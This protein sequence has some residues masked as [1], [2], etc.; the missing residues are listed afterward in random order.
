[1]VDRLALLLQLRKCVGSDRLSLVRQRLAG[2]ESLCATVQPIRTCGIINQLCV[3]DL[4][5]K[6]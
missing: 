5:N 1:M 4:G 3:V 6:T 2:L